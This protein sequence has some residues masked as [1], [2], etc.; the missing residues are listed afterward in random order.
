VVVKVRQRLS[1]SKQAMQKLQWLQ[2]TSQTNGD[3]LNNLRH[4]TSRTFRNKKRVYLKEKMN[5]LGTN[6]T[7]I[8]E[9]YIEA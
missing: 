7:K 5:R 8:S 1:V 6:R 9:S 2:N 3:N 4:E